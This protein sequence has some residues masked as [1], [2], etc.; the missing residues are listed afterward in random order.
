MID[1]DKNSY[2][3]TSELK[4]LILGIQIEVTGLHDHDFVA[5]VMEQFD[6]SGDSRVTEDEFVVGLSNWLIATK[7]EET[8]RKRKRK[9]FITKEKVIQWLYINNISIY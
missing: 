4:A 6:S 7:D 8:V 1:Q 5:K 2:I 9:L 3:S